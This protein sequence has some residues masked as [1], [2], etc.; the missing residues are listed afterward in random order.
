MKTSKEVFWYSSA[1]LG[2][3][4]W[5]AILALIIILNVCCWLWAFLCASKAAKSFLENI[6]CI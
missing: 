2:A 6:Q 4:H 5:V 3:L 1:R